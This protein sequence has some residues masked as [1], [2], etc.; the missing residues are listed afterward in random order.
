[1]SPSYSTRSCNDSS[2]KTSTGWYCHHIFSPSAHDLT[3]KNI[4]MI[5][6][7]IL[8]WGEVTTIDGTQPANSVNFHF[9]SSTITDPSA[10]SPGS[11]I[12][13]TALLNKSHSRITMQNQ[14]VNPSRQL[15][16]PAPQCSCNSCSDP[17]N[18]FIMIQ[19][20][21]SCRLKFSFSAAFS[22][23]EALVT[24]IP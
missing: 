6:G 5:A 7:I 2:M 15:N 20:S 9:G 21:I 22:L 17:N 4:L 8:Q 18:C 10:T 3:F 13:I 14:E 1:M 16:L 12:Y 11:P 19:G 24:L 23:N